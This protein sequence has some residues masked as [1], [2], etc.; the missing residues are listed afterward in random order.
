MFS[1]NDTAARAN[2]VASEEPTAN[3]IH[4]DAAQNAVFH[5]LGRTD[6]ESV[7]PEDE[8]RDLEITGSRLPVNYNDATRFAITAGAISMLTYD[9]DLDVPVLTAPSVIEGKLLRNICLPDRKSAHTLFTSYSRSL[10][11]WYHIYH[12]HTVEALLDTAYNELGLGK[13]PDLGTVAFLLSIFASGAYF[14]AFA[15]W[16][17]SVFANSNEANRLSVYWKESTLDV[18][19]HVERTSN[20]SSIEQLQATIIISLLIQ[21]YECL[22]N[23]YWLLHN[24]SITVAN[25]LSLHV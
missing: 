25:E 18:L 8:A 11:S 6:P 17:E 16:P 12:K 13:L 7:E 10:G 1:K 4:E 3:E 20:S 22:S 14:Q 24:T 2:V 21:N 19:D 15:S 23:K 5:V 9:L